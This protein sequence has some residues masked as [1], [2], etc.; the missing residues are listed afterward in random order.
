[1]LSVIYLLA[2]LHVSKT[3]LA[4][5]WFCS[6]LH[7]SHTF[8]RTNIM[9]HCIRNFLLFPFILDKSVCTVVGMWEMSSS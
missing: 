8:L 5:S 9:Q 7:F 3:C 2:F 6:E 1:M 4:V